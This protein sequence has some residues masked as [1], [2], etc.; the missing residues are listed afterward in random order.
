MCDIPAP[1][2]PTFDYWVRQNALAAG[3]LVTSRLVNEGTPATSTARYL[4]ALTAAS[5]TYLRTGR[6]PT[7]D[8]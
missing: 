2:E 5:E 4:V 6:F 7:P 1:S 3:A 8:R